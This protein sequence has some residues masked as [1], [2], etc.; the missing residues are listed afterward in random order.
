[1][2]EAFYLNQFGRSIA[3]AKG[4]KTIKG[5]VNRALRLKVTNPTVSHVAIWKVS[6]NNPRP[7]YNPGK[8]PDKLIKL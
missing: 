5:Y 1:M 8:A 4:L 3:H 2:L 6:D 7:Y